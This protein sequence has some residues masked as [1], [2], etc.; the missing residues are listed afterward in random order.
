MD[1]LNKFRG[2]FKWLTSVEQKI[3]EITSAKQNTDSKS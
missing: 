3:T 2:F 1:D